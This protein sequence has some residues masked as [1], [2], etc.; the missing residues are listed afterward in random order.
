MT[1]FEAQK[2]ALSKPAETL[3]QELEILP[4]E[5]L[6]DLKERFGI[7]VRKMGADHFSAQCVEPVR[8]WS[9]ALRIGEKGDAEETAE[10]VLLRVAY[11]RTFSDLS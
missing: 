1:F 7:D 4:G 3:R 8:P 2:N 6:D 9:M 5:T 11:I 10:L